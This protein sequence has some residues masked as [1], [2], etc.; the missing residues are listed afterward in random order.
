[1][2]PYMVGVNHKGKVKVWCNENFA[3]NLPEEQTVYI[4]EED[5]VY[6]LVDMIQEATEDYR[7]TR[8]IERYAGSLTFS[9]TIKILN[10]MQSQEGLAVNKIFLD[11]KEYQIEMTKAIQAKNQTLESYAQ[12]TYYE[13]PQVTQTYEIY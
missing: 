13:T 9:N 6:D 12:T 1:M 3:E 10:M 2:T 8:T 5:V 11:L 7:F 4:E